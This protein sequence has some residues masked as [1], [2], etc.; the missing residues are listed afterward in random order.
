MKSRV[1]SYILII[2]FLLVVTLPNI[3]M[4]AGLNKYIDRVTETRELRREH[5]LPKLEPSLQS[6]RE[7][8]RALQAY[9]VNNYGFRSVLVEAYNTI[10]SDYLNNFNER[11][12][13]YGKD[14]WMFWAGDGVLEQYRAI[15]PLTDDQ[16]IRYR[17]I[18]YERHAWCEANGMTYIFI[19]APNKHGIYS[20]YLP[21][22]I[23]KADDMSQTD[24]LAALF[25][26]SEVNYIDVRPVLIENKERFRLYYKF[27]TH[28]NELGAF[29]AYREIMDTVQ[30][31][32]P[33]LNP[34]ELDDFTITYVNRTEG[35]MYYYLG[36]KKELR[37]RVPVLKPDRPYRARKM[38]MGRQGGKKDEKTANVI[39]P[40]YAERS[41]VSQ[42]FIISTVNDPALPKAV[43]FRDSMATAMVPYLS[44]NFRRI[45]YS[46]DYFSHDFK[47]D[48]LDHEKPDIV[49]TEIGERAIHRV[50]EKDNP[51]EVQRA[52]Q[53]EP[54]MPA[55]GPSPPS[56]PDIP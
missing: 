7:Y 54:P 38:Y 42:S 27:D 37:E 3:V 28:W 19:I 15:R 24:Q 44:E 56:S 21:D 17:K 39:E 4:I 53:F 2:I 43:M 31:R 46:W 47:V 10:L 41:S 48:I 13:I 30:E 20:E 6:F 25:Q 11:S 12:V 33:R 14:S 9:Y 35:D 1:Y 32:F 26:E 22:W 50:I 51:P 18:L 40:F 55:R 49:I 29:V 23:D 52:A 16:L 8:F 34:L 45:V 36:M 5:T